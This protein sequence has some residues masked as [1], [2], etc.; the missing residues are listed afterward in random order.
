MNH[1]FKGGYITRFHGNPNKGIN[2]IQLEMSKDLYMSKDE[3]IYDENKAN[4]IQEL[5]KSTFQELIEKLS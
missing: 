3:T 5:L 2:S 4:K 1:P